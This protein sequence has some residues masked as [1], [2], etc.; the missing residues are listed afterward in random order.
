MVV[1]DLPSRPTVSVIVPVYKA[2]EFL[3]YQIAAFATDAGCDGVELVLVLDSP[4]Q[5]EE[6]EM[7]MRALHGLYGVAVR[8]VVHRRNF[9]YAPAVNT[10]V[11]R[12]RGDILVLMNSDVVPATDGWLTALQARLTWGLE[13]DGAASVGAVGPK[14]LFHDDSIQ[15]A[16]MI[17]DRDLRGSYFNRHEFKG[18]PRSYA[19]ANQARP[20]PVL[21]GACLM[22][23]RETFGAVGGLCEDY[24]VGDFEDSDFS[25]RIAA[26]GKSL[27]V[28]PSAELYHY[29]RQSIG[30]N[31]SYTKTRA[32]GY[33]RWLHD[34]RWRPELDRLT[35]ARAAAALTPAVEG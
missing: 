14:L 20:V 27:W 34:S 33:N 30:Q 6:V 8:M 24:V 3:R 35:Q 23:T 11:A 31:D 18:Y 15:H 7:R 4:D 21:T 17:F 9:G 28:E 29:E 2:L 5:A 13:A 26:T 22:L 32:C 10:G 25:L 16:G 12:S 1:G 19:P